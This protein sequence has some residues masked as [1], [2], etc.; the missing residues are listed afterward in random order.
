MYPYFIRIGGFSLPAYP[1]LYGL[2]IAVAGAILIWLGSREGL[3]VR[4]LNNVVLLLAF[5]GLI[6]G[7]LFYAIHFAHEFEGN[8]QKAFNL[9]EAGQVIYGGLLLGTVTVLAY[10][11]WNGLAIR[12]VLDLVATVAPVGIA[13]G[14][15]ACFCRGCCYGEPTNLAWGVHFPVHMDV[16]GQ[17]V[18]SPAFVDHVQQS[19]I[20]ENALHS[21]AVHPVQLCSSALALCIFG[22]MYLAWRSKR[23]E[24][25]LVLLFFIIYAVY[26]FLIEF[27][28]TEPKVLGNLSAAQTTG[29]VI[30]PIC[31]I[32]LLLTRRK[33]NKVVFEKSVRRQRRQR[34][35]KHRRNR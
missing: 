32:L 11:K 9:A 25:R 20:T 13:I 27:L 21:L 3:S 17:V 35:H 30:L 28:R 8:W 23:F 7:R 10:C 1:L 31:L 33:V 4:K 2:G 15:L 14:R 22:I 5:S 24:G 12:K 34:S 19:L 16:T 26:R 18:G 29:L 6:G